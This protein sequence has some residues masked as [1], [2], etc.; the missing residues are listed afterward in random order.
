MVWRRRSLMLDRVVMMVVMMSGGGDRSRGSTVIH[1][2][3]FEQKNAT[4][5]LGRFPAVGVLNNR[6]AW[7][8]DLAHIFP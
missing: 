7:T 2:A 3:R 6:P 4:A 5:A 8:D 1:Y